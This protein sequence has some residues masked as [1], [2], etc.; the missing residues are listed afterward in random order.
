V[1]PP[2]FELVSSR[3][4]SI[5]IKGYGAIFFEEEVSDTEIKLTLFGASKSAAFEHFCDGTVYYS[6]AAD[7]KREGRIRQV[8]A[9]ASPYFTPRAW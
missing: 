6:A 9:E 7:E 4:I 8:I 3:S 5:V 2:L 1:P